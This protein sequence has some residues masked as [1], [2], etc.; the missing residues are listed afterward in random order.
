[1]SSKYEMISTVHAST[2]FL[3]LPA[4]I[5]GVM[6]SFVQCFPPTILEYV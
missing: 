2:F 3:S 6:S 4:A 5:F 1:M